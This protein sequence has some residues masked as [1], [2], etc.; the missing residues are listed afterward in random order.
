MHSN[1]TFFLNPKWKKMMMTEN[2]KALLSQLLQNPSFLCKI[3]QHE[4]ERLIQCIDKPENANDLSMLQRRVH[5]SHVLKPI[6]KNNCLSRFER[7]RVN[8][9]RK[10]SCM[11]ARIV[12]TGRLLLRRYS[13]LQCAASV[14][15]SK[16]E[17]KPADSNV[18]P[19]A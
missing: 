8:S 6:V 11:R 14:V 3:P 16:P 9:P 17:I 2:E 12:S 18:C 1:E 10:F 7:Y 4:L 13:N 19:V 15:M 5:R